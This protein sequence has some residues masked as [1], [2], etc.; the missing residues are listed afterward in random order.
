MKSSLSFLLRSGPRKMIKFKDLL[1]TNSF[2]K[3]LEAPSVSVRNSASLRSLELRFDSKDVIFSAG[4]SGRADL[5]LEALC[6]SLV[7]LKFSEV[8]SFQ[9]KNFDEAYGEDPFYWERKSEAEE[10]IFF[11]AFELL[12]VALDIYRGRE[13]AYE[14]SSPLICRC[15]GVRESDILS[16]VQKEEVVTIEKLALET[17]ASM[18]C[19]SCLPQ[20]RKLL[21]VP[22][23][24]EKRLIA[25][26][27]KADW[28]LLI[29]E[30]L[31]IFPFTQE[32]NLQVEEFTRNTVIISYSKNASQ[33]EEEGLGKKLQGFLGSETTSDLV[34]F[35]RRR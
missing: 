17:K 32:W 12:H 14:E 34:F 21:N 4:Y 33:K 5:W 8:Q 20:L 35:L 26:K 3:S 24:S 31:R 18:G 15:F 19:R 1:L 11:E 7:G 13:H 9:W 23:E 30:A 10:E 6:Q 2:N 22:V 27:S 28:I 25:G 16:F 29:D